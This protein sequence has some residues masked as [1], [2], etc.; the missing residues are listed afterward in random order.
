MVER[1]EV[2]LDVGFDA[3]AGKV[4]INIRTGVLHL[5]QEPLV[6]H[7]LLVFVEVFDGLGWLVGV[8]PGVLLDLLDA[9]S[10]SWFRHQD[11]VDQV[12]DLV[13][14]VAGVLLVSVQDLLVQALSVL[15]FEGQMAANQAE[16][17]HACT[18][19]VCLWAHVFQAL[20]QLR[21]SVA[22]G[23]TGCH[24]LLVLLEGVAESKVNN[25]QVLL[26]IKQ[27]VLRLDV[28]VSDA[29]LAQVFDTIDQLLEQPTGLLF[30]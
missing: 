27:Q 9:I 30:G 21:G 18:P 29:K 6:H 5:A 22:R 23:T 20:D 19:D 10:E 14:E 15:V 1:R 16:Q 7:Y 28:P 11:V 17:H 25:L 4:D 26:L 24:Q 8:E 2:V 3:A 13:R 12:F